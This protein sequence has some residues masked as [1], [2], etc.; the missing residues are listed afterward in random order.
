MKFGVPKTSMRGR[1]MT[2]VSSQTQGKTVLEIKSWGQVFLAWNFWINGHHSYGSHPSHILVTILGRHNTADHDINLLQASSRP[3]MLV[4]ALGPGKLRVFSL[5][6]PSLT[7]LSLESWNHHLLHSFS[8][9]F[10]SSTAFWGLTT[11]YRI[12]THVPP[13]TPTWAYFFFFSLWL[14]WQ[15]IIHRF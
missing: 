5:H 8:V 9:L 12:N 13:L 11:Q 6:Y 14:S 4:Q 10:S 7:K 2:Q 1:I 3:L 15:L